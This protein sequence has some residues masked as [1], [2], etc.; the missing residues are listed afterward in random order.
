MHQFNTSIDSSFFALCILV[1]ASSRFAICHRRGSV[2]GSQF[3]AEVERYKDRNQDRYQ[4]A[5]EQTPTEIKA[6]NPPH[7]PNEGKHGDRCH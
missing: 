5:W 7:D 4:H 6:G 1:Q 2:F 3:A